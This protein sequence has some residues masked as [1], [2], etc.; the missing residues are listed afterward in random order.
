[1][2]PKSLRSVKTDD[3]MIHWQFPF[4]PF[5]WLNWYLLMSRCRECL[6]VIYRNVGE[7]IFGF[8]PLTEALQSA[9][10]ILNSRIWYHYYRLMHRLP[11]PKLAKA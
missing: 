6:E 9:D 5:L 4:H 3:A 2:V 8:P 11:S 1:M 7:C 10:A